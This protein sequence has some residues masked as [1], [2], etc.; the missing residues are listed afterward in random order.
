ME[1]TLARQ[2][3]KAVPAAPRSHAQTDGLDCS[4]QASLPAS[5]DLST[6]ADARAA[7]EQ[8]STENLLQ[9]SANGLRSCKEPKR[10]GGHG[11]DGAPIGDGDSGSDARRAPPAKRIRKR[12]AR[13]NGVSEAGDNERV[14]LLLP[15]LRALAQFDIKSNA[16]N[17]M[18]ELLQEKSKPSRG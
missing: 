10:S 2:T 13:G 17:V 6:A 4:D 1:K 18:A 5:E 12:N 9:A 7:A 11:P 14:S 3:R 15:L 16:G 8:G